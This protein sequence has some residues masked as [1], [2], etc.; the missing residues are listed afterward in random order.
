MAPVLAGLGL[1]Y[2]QGTSAHFSQATALAGYYMLGFLFGGNTLLVTWMIANTAGQT[3]KSGV[4]VVYNIASSV[5]NIVG[6]S[7]AH[8]ALVLYPAWTHV[9][10]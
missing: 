3:K 7:A 2:S 6:E 4:M 9:L 8:L 10:T 1:L 5:G